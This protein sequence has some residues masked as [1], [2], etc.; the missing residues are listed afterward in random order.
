MLDNANVEKEPEVGMLSGFL[1]LLLGLVFHI[2]EGAYLSL[3]PSAAAIISAFLRFGALSNLHLN[4]GKSVV[5]P[6]DG[7]S[8]D[9]WRHVL[10]AAHPGWQ[11]RPKRRTR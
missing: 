8:H 1:L 5:I 4:M 6:L 11:G 7:C 9:E 3:V 2:P 10:C